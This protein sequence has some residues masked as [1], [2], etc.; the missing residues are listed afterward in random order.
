MRISVLFHNVI[1]QIHLFSHFLDTSGKERKAGSD[2][3]TMTAW[4][5]SLFCL[6]WLT[7]KSTSAGGS[8]KNLQCKRRRFSPWVRRSPGGGHGNTV[9]Y[10]CL[11]N[12]M[13]RGAWR[14]RVRG[15]TR[16]QS[17]LKW[18]ST[19]RPHRHTMGQK[20][21]CTSYQDPQKVSTH[22]RF[23]KRADRNSVVA[24]R[25]TGQACPNFTQPHQRKEIWRAQNWV[26]THGHLR[27]RVQGSPAF[28]RGEPG[29]PQKQDGW[30]IWMTGGR[31]GPRWDPLLTA[32][33]QM[34]GL[35]QQRSSLL[36]QTVK[37][38]PVT[39]ETQVR[40]LGGENP[41]EKKM[42]THSSI[43]AWGTSRTEEPSR[44]QSTGLQRVGYNWGTNTFTFHCQWPPLWPKWWKVVTSPTEG[45]KS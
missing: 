23:W 16:T 21:L 35:W 17:R 45:V 6:L 14:A 13:G 18:L 22:T 33:R 1:L 36:P 39:Q 32:T 27:G 3:S 20:G 5:I 41:P 4:V 30:W 31:N 28:L 2:T 43:L 29:T 7:P 8:V 38:L 25:L 37:N 44:L 19:A 9:Q 12:S 10:S 11:E 40:F 34:A 24:V 26:H 42:A 15:H